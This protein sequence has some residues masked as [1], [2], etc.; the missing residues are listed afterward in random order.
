M[1]KVL[2]LTLSALLLMSA[3]CGCGDTPAAG[4]GKNNDT[5]TGPE[6]AGGGSGQNK[7]TDTDGNVGD[8][9]QDTG[10]PSDAGGQDSSDAGKTS[11]ALSF[12]DLP[13]TESIGA[14]YLGA[15]TTAEDLYLEADVP[16]IR[17]ESFGFGFITSDSLDYAIVVASETTTV[18]GVTV[19]DAFSEVYS[20]DFRSMLVNFNRAKYADLSLSSTEDV[21][22][23]GIDAIRFSGVQ[24]ADDYGTPYTYDVYGYCLVYAEVPIVVAAVT[25]Q[26]EVDADTVAS[27]THYVDEMVQTI[28]EWTP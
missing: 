6:N 5:V 10:A 2:A 12:A 28:R 3:L 15:P 4:S 1:K 24:T 16:D 11:G 26:E 21:T 23:C 20:D 14:G 18:P 22:V 13:K 19:A 27:L 8:A 7:D 9:G 17:T 25:L